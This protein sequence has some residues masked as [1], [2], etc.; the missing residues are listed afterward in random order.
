[1]LVQWTAVQWVLLQWVL[2]WAQT[3]P[4]LL[5]WQQT[6]LQKL[7]IDY[8]AGVAAGSAPRMSLSVTTS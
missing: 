5:A 7:E 4:K 8:R 1:V 3:G 2:R 6:L